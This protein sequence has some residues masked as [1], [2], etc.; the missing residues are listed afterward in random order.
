MIAGNP[1]RTGTLLFSPASLPGVDA[2]ALV[3]LLRDVTLRQLREGLSMVQVLLTGPSP[4]DA[5]ILGRAGFQFL[6]QLQYMRMDVA[7]RQPAAPEPRLT[8]KAMDPLD[9]TQLAQVIVRSY[10]DSKD[11]PLL[12][13]KRLIADVIASHKASG[14]FTPQT[15]WI[16]QWESRPAGCLLVNDSAH[17]REAELV[18]LGV[19][20]EFRGRGLCRA[21]V[22]LAAHETHRRGRGALTLA[23][24]V[25]NCYA[26]RVYEAEGF[27]GGECRWAYAAFAP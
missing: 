27:V 23:V 26:V 6:A 17:P 1:G 7:L 11:C 4:A 2:Q 13:G 14:A 18:Y 25:A 5:D 16:A 20:P 12:C 10:E 15:W 24:D 21:M 8:W 22:R 19:T 9:E 3:V